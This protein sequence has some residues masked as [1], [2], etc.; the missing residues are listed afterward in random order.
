MGIARIDHLRQVA[1][2][3][4]P[5]QTRRARRPKDGAQARAVAQF[6]YELARHDPGL[7]TT[8]TLAWSAARFPASASIPR[9]LASFFG[10]CSSAATPRRPALRAG[11]AAISSWAHSD[12]GGE[13]PDG[14]GWLA[15]A[16]SDGWSFGSLDEAHHEA[17]WLASNLSLSVREVLR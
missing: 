4:R 12:K 17:N 7:N 16:G 5:N 14:E 15:L 2:G 1:A 6:T 9:S 8:I 3:L 11:S 13:T 10:N